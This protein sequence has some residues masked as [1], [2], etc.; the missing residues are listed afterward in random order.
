VKAAS[1]TTRY[2]WI[3]VSLFVLIFSLEYAAGYYVSHVIGYVHSD[4]M[5]RVAN[6]FY[7]LYSQDP[8]LGAIGFVWNPLPS[9]MELIPLLFY[10]LYTPLASSALA[11]VLMTAA[12]AAGTAVV[13]FR[14]CLRFGQ[15]P[16]F[17]LLF[18]LLFCLNPFIFLFGANG[19]SDA[20][21]L[22]FIMSAVLSFCLWVREKG[23]GELVKAAF[24][25]ALAFWTRYEA[26][27]LGAAMGA[28]VL[29]ATA[30]ANKEA[31]LGKKKTLDHDKEYRME[32]AAA[33]EAPSG[34]VNRP[35]RRFY[36]WKAEGSVILLLL[37]IVYSGLMWLILNKLIMKDWLYF[38]NS[39]YSNVAQSAGLAG[40]A[41]FEAMKGNI[42]LTLVFAS[43]KALYYSAPLGAV[44][45]LRIWNRRFVLW[46]L[47]ILMLLYSSI[48]SL[49]MLLLL[50]GSSYGWLRYFMYV[51]PI[52][53]AWLPYELSRVKKS[54]INKGLVLASLAATAVILTRA[55]A[56]PAIAPDENKYLHAKVHANIQKADKEIAAIL[57][58]EYADDLI[59]MDSYSTYG[60]ILNSR[61]PQR[62]L[63][64]SDF[65]FKE[66]FGNP[67]AFGV[68]YILSP[69]PETY[70]AKSYEEQI[71]PGFYQNGA[72]W[73]RLVREVGGRWRLYEVI[74]EGGESLGYSKA[75]AVDHHT[76]L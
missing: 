54:F 67:V 44:V 3:S 38:L 28:G 74:R 45:L 32:A 39:D 53:V 66:A 13:L 25:L 19:L 1:P 52:T 7:V 47:V 21:F 26:V 2:R 69:K 76:G 16:L 5:S 4:S 51:F 8:H 6:A 9:L 17:S 34:Q 75:G 37:P 60:V 64:T 33:A 63:I 46:D 55:M 56:D 49:Q 35:P 41:S 73:C 62:Y 59:L 36:L 10:R 30:F 71:Y 27:P 57:D 20:P 22:F 50:K 12:F 29:L 18:S 48:I 15:G 61:R 42:W 58:S 68:D 65:K 24:A 14:G 23:T 43:K 11:G 72:P 40:Q 70:S 31:K